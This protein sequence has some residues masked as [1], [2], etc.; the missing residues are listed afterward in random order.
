MKLNR[1]QNT[2]GTVCGHR[3]RFQTLA[4]LIGCV[5]IYGITISL[6]TPL[7]SLILEGR[8]VSSTL[9]GGLAMMAPLGVILGSIFVPRC[10]QMFSGRRLLLIAIG[11]EIFLIF[12]LLA[13][14][15]L[16]SWFVIRFF[17]G[18]TGSVLFI[19]SESWMAEI[20]P[21]ATRGRVMGLYNTVLASSFA[22]GPLILTMTGA[23][24]VLP[25]LSGIVLMALAALPLVLAGRYLPESSGKASFNVLSFFRVAP[26]LVFGCIVVAFKD[27]AATSLLPV[28]GVRSGL[29]ESLAV[30]MLF[31]GALGGAV[32][33]IPIGWLADHY[34]RLWVLSSCGIFGM[35]GVA[36]LPFVVTIP[37]LL[38]LVVFL[39]MGFFAGIYTVVMTLAGQW[40]RGLEL[41]TAMAAFGVF[42]GLGGVAGPL[43]SGVA[44]DLWNPHGLPAVF[45]G[46]A[47]VFVAVSLW[48][49]WRHPARRS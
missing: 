46:V 38:C 30:L 2:L 7:L 18:V 22:I 29:T 16:A 45:L 34:N 24:G 28:Y 37:W 25:F 27:M 8:T 40:F 20:T 33:Q 31:F 43:V 6:F 10:L 12:L 15:D 41:A 14:N 44:M 5:S 42:W 13:V 26:L 4:A 17:M 11:F 1:R 49:R 48:P 21:D 3:D 9:I 19:V 32:L 36:A 47:V 39:W 35:L 23:N